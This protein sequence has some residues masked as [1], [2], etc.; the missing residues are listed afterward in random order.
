MR[1]EVNEATDGETSSAR[2]RER[3]DTPQHADRSSPLLQILPRSGLESSIVTNSIPKMDARAQRASPDIRLAFGERPDT[4]GSR[5]LLQSWLAST[6]ADGRQQSEQELARRG[7][8]TLTK[9]LVQQYFSDNPRERMQ[10]VDRVLA[11][12]GAGSSAWLLLLAED[13]DAEVRLLA[14]TFIATSNDAQLVEKAWQV[15]IRDHDPRIA[16]LAGRLRDRR[17]ATLRR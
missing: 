11:L 9:P 3:L 2:V 16:D 13:A 17:S 14:V 10:L 15:A 7:F 5:E 8:G 1:R 4:A 6:D 12:P